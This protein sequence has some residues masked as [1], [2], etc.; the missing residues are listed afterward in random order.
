MSSRRVVNS[1]QTR[2]TRAAKRAA[3]GR[4]DID[5]RLLIDR[6]G[7]LRCGELLHDLSGE[8][9][10][11]RI[12]AGTMGS[13]R[14]FLARLYLRGPVWYVAICRLTHAPEAQ[15]AL[16]N[17]T[18]RLRLRD[19]RRHSRDDSISLLCG[20]RKHTS[21]APLGLG[22]TIPNHLGSRGASRTGRRLTERQPSKGAYNHSPRIHSS[23]WRMPSS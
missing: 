6:L 4:L 23:V 21:R 14:T 1:A 5:A 7:N 19:S 13:L 16:S 12:P 11:R 22:R 10:G 8:D 18:Q 17:I 9:V 2:R 3:H 15:T 20:R